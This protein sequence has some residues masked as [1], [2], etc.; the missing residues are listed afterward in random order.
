MKKKN[1]E[2]FLNSTENMAAANLGRHAAPAA[3]VAVD[4][5]RGWCGLG[6]RVRRYIKAAPGGVPLRY[7]P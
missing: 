6:A 4:R 3:A 7:G 1:D 5:A 2:F